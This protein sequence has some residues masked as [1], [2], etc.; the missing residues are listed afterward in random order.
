MESAFAPFKHYMQLLTTGR[1]DG[2]LNSHDRDMKTSVP[3][4]SISNDPNLL[5]YDLGNEP[6]MIEELFVDGTVYAVC[7]YPFVAVVN[8]AH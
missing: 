7:Y 3:D 2:Y 8:V 6:A 4:M 1:L 5:L